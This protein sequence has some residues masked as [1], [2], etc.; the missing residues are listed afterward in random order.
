M[1]NKLLFVLV[2][3]SS[4]VSAQK[5]YTTKSGQIKFFSNTAVEDVEAINN[6]V[7]CALNTASGKVQF[8]VLI[9]GFTFE[10]SLMQKHFNEEEYMHSNK[11]PKAVFNGSI[12]NTSNVNFSKEGTQTVTVEGN[13][14]MHDVIKKI[15]AKGTLTIANN[16]VT[17]NS[18]FNIN[19][20]DYKIT[21]PEGINNTIAVTVNCKLE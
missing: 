16:K 19:P 11:F 18:K 15:T 17:L 20:T 2:F 13:L 3:V 21:V 5:N 8:A 10:N 4:I 12:S 14:N 6:Q 9:K 7:Y 1:K